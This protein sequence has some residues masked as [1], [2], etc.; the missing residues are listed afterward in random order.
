[1]M[2]VVENSK[3]YKKVGEEFCCSNA[4]KLKP[5]ASQGN[6]IVLPNHITLFF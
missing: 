4:C 5:Q 1:M 6:N 2:Y 3:R